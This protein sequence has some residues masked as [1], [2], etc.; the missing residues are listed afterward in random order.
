MTAGAAADAV[1]VAADAADAGAG[2]DNRVEDV[3]ATSRRLR[4]ARGKRP[5][6]DA[7]VVFPPLLTSPTPLTPLT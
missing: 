5:R 3:C 1:V 4:D 2:V 7:D 6:D